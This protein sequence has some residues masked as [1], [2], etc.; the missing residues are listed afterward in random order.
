[1]SKHG[2]WPV[3]PTVG[4]KD[5]RAGSTA[6]LSTRPAAALALGGAI[7]MPTGV[8]RSWAGEPCR[9]AGPYPSERG[10]PC[11]ARRA[12]RLRD[13]LN[14][15]R[16]ERS[17]GRQLSGSE[18]ELSSGVG[19]RSCAASGARDPVRPPVADACAVWDGWLLCSCPATGCLTRPEPPRPDQHRLI[20]PLTC[21]V[22]PP[23]PK[24]PFRFV[25]AI[26]RNAGPCPVPRTP[27]LL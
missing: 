14:F 1:M 6:C 12:T 26:T 2:C 3:K 27:M 11:E 23:G 7:P 20:L 8:R 15:V 10:T 25:G 19:A 21:S 4:S 16:R 17:A 24:L 5:T 13:L 18:P 9:L 22:D